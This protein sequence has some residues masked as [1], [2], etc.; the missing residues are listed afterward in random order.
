MGVGHTLRLDGRATTIVFSWDKGTPA[1]IYYGPMLDTDVSL[2]ELLAAH[3]RPLPKGALD[4]NLPISLHPELGRGFLGH[5]ALIAHRPSSDRPGWAGRFTFSRYTSI[6]NGVIFGLQDGERGL[7]LELACVLDPV[8][9]VLT[10]SARLTNIADSE[11]DIEWLSVPVLAPSQE[12]SEQLSFFGRWCAEFDIERL[13]VTMG[14]IETRKSPGRT[15]HEAF[16]GCI[17]LNPT[18]DEESGPCLAMHLGWSGNHRLILERL[19]TGDIQIQMGVLFF[20]GEGRLKPGQTMQT[21]CL[22]TAHSSSGL[23]D[24]SQKLHQHVRKEILKLPNPSKPRPVT[25]NT[26]EAIYFDH[27]HERLTALADA[28]AEVGD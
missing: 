28:A 14:L 9:D 8:S 4:I 23:N 20:S 24:V 1:A 2:E 11:I 10:S 6:E 17:L 5:P 18:T 3:R 21:P 26:W 7:D 22:Y 27:T 25:V 12:F 13:P 16:P 19:S 15:S